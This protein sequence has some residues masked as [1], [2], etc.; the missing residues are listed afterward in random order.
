MTPRRRALL[1]VGLILILIGIIIFAVMLLRNAMAPPPA[2]LAPVEP[3]LTQIA[4]SPPAPSD[5]VN[6]LIVPAEAVSGSTA[7]RQMAELFAERYGSYSNQGE[8]ENL[9]DLLPIMTARYRRSTETF[10]KTAEAVPGQPFEGVTSKKVSTQ[11]RDLDEDSAVIAVA[12]QQERTSGSAA[13]A[14]GYRTLRMEL[15]LVGSDWRV[16]ASSWEN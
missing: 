6:P 3:D 13:P 7:S 15:Q 14:I 16:D 5:F 4:E 2:V 10:L 9:R 8:Y 12:L 1:I 11:I